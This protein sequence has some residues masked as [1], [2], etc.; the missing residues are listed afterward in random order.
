M[1]DM[2]SRIF[3]YDELGFFRHTAYVLG[4]LKPDFTYEEL[5]IAKFDHL[6]NR[7]VYDPESLSNRGKGIPQAICLSNIEEIDFLPLPM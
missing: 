5:G 6:T 1:N 4:L 7:L 3:I 2:L